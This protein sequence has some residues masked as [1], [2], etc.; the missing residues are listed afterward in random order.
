MQA[1]GSGAVDSLPMASSHPAARRSLLG[2]AV[3]LAALVAPAAAWGHASF[4]GASP[5][6]GARTET[7][8][9]RIELRFTEPLIRRLSRATL[10]RADGAPVALAAQGVDGRRLVVRPAA[11]L[12]TGAY[13]VR[14][15]TVS[16][17]DGHALEGVFSFGVRAPAGSAAHALE[18]SPFARAGAVRIVA[19]LALY[20][21]ALLFVGGL[22]LGVLTGRGAAWVAPARDEAVDGQA[23]AAREQRTV[24]RLGW[25]AATSAAG[26]VLVEAVDAAGG[27]S[28]SAIGAFLLSGTAGL[29]RLLA[30]L[31]LGGAAALA[32]RRRERA[33]ALALLA[34]AA[35]AMSGHAGSADPRGPSILN[36]WVHLVSGAVW[37][38]GI[39]VLVAVLTPVVRRGGP[40]ARTALSREVLPRF[41]R[42]AIPAF[43]VVSLSGL[44]SL[45]LQL[46]SPEALWTTVYG[47]VL[48]AKVVLVGAIAAVSGLHAGVLRQRATDGGAWATRP[49]WALV[50]AEPVIGFMVVTAV[51]VL[52]TFPLPPRQLEAAQAARSVVPL[53]DPC[54]LPQVASGELPVAA[55]AGT[56]VVAGW[57]RRDGRG[58][59]GTVR[60]LDR[61]GRASPA[62]FR[63]LGAQQRACGRGCARFRIEGSAREVAVRVGTGAQAAT[64]RLPAR[65]RRDSERVAARLVLRVERAMRELSGVREIE[66]VTSGPGTSA[67]TVYELQAPDRMRMRTALGAERVVIGDRQWLRT[68]DTPWGPAAPGAGA[69]F[70]LRSW[71]RWQPYAAAARVLARRREAGR[72]V[73]E[74]ALAQPAT[75]VWHRLVIDER[76]GRVLRAV[77]TS[78]GHTTTSRYDGFGARFDI[79]AP[80]VG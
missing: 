42:I 23:L 51:A 64:A 66:R 80:G 4:V 25:M 58:L 26:V 46:G 35:L 39:G 19:R 73:V 8:P 50:R 18:Q 70:S 29:P 65:W 27:L 16:P 47:R 72:R 48:L 32:G 78:P 68:R 63:V 1:A 30:A 56:A 12:P 53:C 55:R 11:V 34:L 13:V 54:P 2:L 5:M 21:T 45:L 49:H 71:F 74:V 43:A 9:S 41:G 77:A 24:G 57:V 22:L 52:V 76:T 3:A 14:W 44:I 31:A 62:P 69:A 38:G 60:V 59:S 17:E 75:P 6:P 61:S 79:E 40:G 36:G 15:R 33:A 28:P 10:R 20:V 37:L 67:L 7:A